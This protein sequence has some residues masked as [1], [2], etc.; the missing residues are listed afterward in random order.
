MGE[1]FV[2]QLVE[3]ELILI[4]KWVDADGFGI[5]TSNDFGLEPSLANMFGL[6]DHLI[7]ILHP[8]R[9]TSNPFESFIN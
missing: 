8:S 2:A 7:N 6:V 4:G 3:N 5:I 1:W 9:S